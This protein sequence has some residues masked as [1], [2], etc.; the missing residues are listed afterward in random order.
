MNPVSGNSQ[1][2]TK[3]KTEDTKKTEADD[4]EL[5]MI[6]VTEKP[7]KPDDSHN[8]PGTQSVIDAAT[9]EQ[10]MIRNL[11][12]LIRYEPGVNVGNDPQRFGASGITIR[13][14]GGNR[15][16]MQVDGVRLPEAFRIGSFSNATRNMVD[17][18]AL[19]A[20]EIVRGT[21]SA[22]YGGDAMGG[23][24]NFVTKDPTDYLKVFGNDYYGSAK[25]NYNTTDNGLVQTATLAGALDNWESMVLFTHSQSNE[26]DN[27]G[28]NDSLGG[29]RTTPSPQDN[30]S[31]NVLSKLLYRFNDDNVLR[32]T[33]EWLQTQSELDALFAR[34]PDISLRNVN[35]MLTT[36]DQSRWRISLDHTLKNLA[37]PLFDEALWRIYTQTT[38]TGQ[39]TVQDRT[40]PVDGNTLTRRIFQ[41]DNDDI[42]GELKLNRRFELWGSRHALQYGG[43]INQNRIA[44]LRDGSF[45][46]VSGS[47]NFRGQPTQVCPKGK[48]TKAVI[49]DDFPVRDFP[50]ST[51]TKAGAYVEDRIELL[52][53]RIELIPGGR[54]EYFRLRPHPDHLFEKVSKEA[55]LSGADPIIPS[56]I[57]RYD[58]LPRF[59][60]LLHVDDVFSVHGRYTHGFRGP[61]FSESNLGFT[62]ANFGYSVVPNYN[63]V[64][65]TSVDA[66]VGVRGQSDSGEFDITVFRN[67]Y[68]NFIFGDVICDPATSSCPPL[69]FLTM[70]TVN[71]QDEIRIQG[72]EI[73]SRLNLDTLSPSLLGASLLFS[74][75]HIE[76]S[77]LATGRADDEALRAISPIKAVIGL[78]YDQPDGDWGTETMLTLV[79]AK[80]ASTA[81]A[82]V[83]YLPDGYGVVDFNAYYN[84]DRHISLNVGVFNLFDKKYIDWEDTNT[85]AGDPHATL[86]NF[87][88]AEFWADRFSR[89]GRNLGVTLRIAY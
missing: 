49:P 83:Q 37:T 54:W 68:Q 47:V 48:I 62:N 19:K 42:G 40:S 36:D 30:Q 11:K 67:D 14:L 26:T 71:S 81:P 44:Q 69:G 73:K 78:R 66:E 65:E 60:A 43:Q 22:Y 24:V 61:N 39:L 33:G 17:M 10:R 77:N 31:Y 41:Y 79:T 57:D 21:G 1:P 38:A 12:D 6:E 85:R 76:G 5:D 35:Q 51:V 4:T 15:V 18:D 32:L 46:C 59:G 2:D 64:P 84:I 63:I 23:S 45:E 89:P 28:T 75:A 72:I 74:A 88:A 27:M 70:Q 34:G 82:D 53:R 52:Q 86:G 87:A 55:V 13:G 58:F 20:V 3:A 25:L 56:I 8:Q 7:D 16:L 9:I 80:R 29:S 50:L